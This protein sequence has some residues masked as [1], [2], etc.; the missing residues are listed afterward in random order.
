MTEVHTATPGLDN[1]PVAA[2]TISFIDGAIGLLEYRGY[3]INALARKSNIEEVIYLLMFGSLPSASEWY[4]F[5]HM[6]AQYRSLPEEYVESLAGIP[7][8]IQPVNQLQAAV[9]MLPG[10]PAAGTP[11][12]TDTEDATTALRLI[13]QMP[14][15]VA[16]LHRHTEGLEYIPPDSGLSHAHNFLYM[17][18]GRKADSLAVSAMETCLI[19][20]AEQ[21]INTSTFTARIAASVLAQPV[22]AAIAALASLSGSLHGG[23]A[24]QVMAMIHDIGTVDG[25]PQYVTR[26]LEKPHARIMG[27]G[28][29]IYNTMD[30]RA[31]ILSNLIPRLFARLGATLEQQIVKALEKEVTERLEDKGVFP[32]VD[33]KTGIVYQ[34]LGIRTDFFTNVFAAA[35]IVGWMAHWME[36]RK[37]HKVIRPS[38][39]YCGD[40]SLNYTP[41]E[42]R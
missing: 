10:Y 27:F 16:A 17:L 24:E 8:N 15:I 35:R 36:E 26:T 18:H 5:R 41:I 28:H 3:N 9:A 30:P 6:L 31:A 25:V 1:V 11:Q 34:R 23:A 42:L 33:L 14:L 2:S 7:L 32:N 22:M 39:L 29:R 13:C 12:Q 20:Y 37:N 19:L 4:Q 21:T 38:Q 40:R